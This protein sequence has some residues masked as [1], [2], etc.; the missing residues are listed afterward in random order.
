M[1]GYLGNFP[2]AYLKKNVNAVESCKFFKDNKVYMSFN[3][4]HTKSEMSSV[5]LSSFQV[6]IRI[7]SFGHAV[8]P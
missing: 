7:S 3:L 6:V 1:P 8:L 2:N 4:E 5:C